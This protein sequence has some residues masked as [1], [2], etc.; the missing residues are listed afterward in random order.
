MDEGDI[1]APLY[2]VMGR[3]ADVDKVQR[4]LSFTPCF[5]VVAYNSEDKA[6]IEPHVSEVLFPP[7]NTACELI[8]EHVAR[9]SGRPALI[10]GEGDKLKAVYS[11]GEEETLC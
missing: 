10:A 5:Y 4:L 2:Y 6:S 8:A 1:K 11:T 3:K 9:V 7:D